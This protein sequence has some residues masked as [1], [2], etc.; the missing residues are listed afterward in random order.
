MDSFPQ[1]KFNFWNKDILKNNTLEILNKS[2]RRKIY[3]KNW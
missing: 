1:G 2:L 3:K